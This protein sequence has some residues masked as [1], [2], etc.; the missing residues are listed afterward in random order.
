MS[1]NTINTPN[2]IPNN[3]MIKTRQL[4]NTIHSFE[5]KILFDKHRIILKCLNELL[6]TNYKKISDVQFNNK[7]QLVHDKTQDIIKSYIT[8]LY[9]VGVISKFINYNDNDNDNDNQNKK[10]NPYSFIIN[11]LKQIRYK[12]TQTVDSSNNIILA[13]TKK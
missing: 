6:K 12:I 10:I 11:I 13:C 2:N 3:T 4:Y 9:D 5:Q 8:Q 1:D 7:K